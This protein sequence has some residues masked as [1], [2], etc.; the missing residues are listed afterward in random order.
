MKVLIVEDNSDVAHF[1][2]DLV[3]TEHHD[4]R[5][6]VDGAHGLAIYRE[7]TPDL[8]ITDIE[9]PTMTGLEL[10]E[11]IRADDANTIVVIITAHGS[12]DYAIRALRLGAANYLKKPVHPGELLQLIRKYQSVVAN[13]TMGPTFPG[14]TVRREFTMRFETRVQSAHRIADYLVVEAAEAL[15]E[16]ER[17]AVHLGLLELLVNAMEHGNLRITGTEKAAAFQSDTLYDLYQERQADPVL[18]KRGVTVDF[19]FD[20]NGCE[21]TIADEGEGFDWHAH[22]DTVNSANLM[23]LT[24]RG[25]AVARLQFDELHYLGEGNVVRARKRLKAGTESR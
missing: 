4:T 17:L 5:L 12:E 25:I 11:A 1:L 18:G 8:V 23:A 13:R 24:G 14:R 15:R 20:R 9:M 21:W 2:V 6:A 10:L 16:E 19:K 7:Y 22:G 3:S